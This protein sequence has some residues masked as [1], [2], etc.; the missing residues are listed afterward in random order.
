MIFKEF[1][2]NTPVTF[3]KAHTNVLRFGCGTFHVIKICFGQ[4][5]KCYKPLNFKVSSILQG[6]AVY[7]SQQLVGES[8]PCFRRERAAS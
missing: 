3:C 1:N 2:L 6:W 7:N 5:K 8:N 4:N